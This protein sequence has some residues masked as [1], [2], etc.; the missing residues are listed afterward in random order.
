VKRASVVSPTSS[1]PG[2]RSRGRRGRAK[3]ALD[4]SGKEELHDRRLQEL[5]RPPERRRPDP[6]RT[7]REI[8][9]VPSGRVPFESETFGGTVRQERVHE[10]AIASKPPDFGMSTGILV[11]LPEFW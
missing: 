4:L 2:N 6:L 10:V 5:G 1:S 3:A 8:G 11:S 7:Q 9:A